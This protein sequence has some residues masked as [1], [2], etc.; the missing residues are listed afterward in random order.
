MITISKKNGIF[1]EVIAS[2]SHEQNKKA[3]RNNRTILNP[4][5]VFFAQQKLSKSHWAEI[6]K[7]VVYLQKQSLI[8]QGNINI[9]F[10]YLMSMFNPPGY[11]RLKHLNI[12]NQAWLSSF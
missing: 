8:T 11:D 12:Q 1:Y 4:S 6:T 3:R 5:K 7:V 9:F 10:P 2:Y